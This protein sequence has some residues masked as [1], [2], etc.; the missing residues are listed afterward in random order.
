M[1]RLRS[2]RDSMCL[3]EA[4]ISNML[5]IAAIM[6]VLERKGLCTKQDL[7]DIVNKLRQ[8]NPRAKIREMA[9]PDPVPA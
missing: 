6:D 1:D 3:E 2:T 4:T 8:K 9:S 7:L 5:E